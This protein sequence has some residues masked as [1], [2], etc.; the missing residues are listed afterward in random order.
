MKK[1]LMIS[2]LAGL[3]LNGL[4]AEP[5]ADGFVSVFNGKDLSGW[6][7]AT[8]SCVVRDGVLY[9]LPYKYG[10]LMLE[11]QYADFIL[12]F[13]FL[14]TTNGNNGV[15][16]R[17]KDVNGSATQSGMELQ[18][19]DDDG[20]QYK[21]LH[22]YQYNG[23]IYGVVPAKRGFLKPVGQWNA[24]EVRAIGSR[25]TIVLNGTVIVDADLKEVSKALDGNEHPGLHNAKGYLGLMAHY[26]RVGF[27]NI[28]I[29]EIK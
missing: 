5:S 9:S 21:N 13:E 25:I 2:A 22:D 12:R 10:N 17:M 20:N 6:I 26:S 18:I 8:Q 4:A 3:V 14:M 19:L 15:V 7:G 29:K 1:V 11:R 27:R 28:R 23:S 16:I 24:E